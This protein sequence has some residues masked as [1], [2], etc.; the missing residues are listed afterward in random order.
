LAAANAACACGQGLLIKYLAAG[1]AAEI[2]LQ[3]RA[4][5]FAG[6]VHAETLET[7]NAIRHQDEAHARFIALAHAL[8]NA[9][10]VALC[11]QSNCAHQSGNACAKNC[12]LHGSPVIMT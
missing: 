5:V 1:A 12:D 6:Q 3:R 4:A 8:V 2:P 10:A 11:A 9:A 7:I